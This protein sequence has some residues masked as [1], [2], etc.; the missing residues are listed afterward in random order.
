[1]TKVKHGSDFEFIKKTMHWLIQNMHQY[2]CLLTVSEVLWHSSEGKLT[3]NASDI[4]H[5][6]RLIQDYSH[7]SQEP[8]S[9]RIGEGF[10]SMSC[11]FFRHIIWNI[12]LQMSDISSQ[13]LSEFMWG[14]R[15][16]QPY[17][18]LQITVM[19][20]AC[21][22]AMVGVTGKAGWRLHTVMSQHTNEG[23]T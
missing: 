17:T 23:I 22:Q 12:A 9:S 6:K 16:R 5:W 7:I 21:Y 14:I 11:I 8:I 19:S 3:R 15:L 4:Y 13:L 2:I 10:Q 18:I 1:M 20:Q